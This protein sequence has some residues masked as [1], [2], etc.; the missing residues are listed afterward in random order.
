MLLKTMR[1]LMGTR[2]QCIL[3]RVQVWELSKHL[4]GPYLDLLS[5]TLVDVLLLQL[6]TIFV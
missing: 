3:G 4:F 5:I 1:L 6:G 2:A